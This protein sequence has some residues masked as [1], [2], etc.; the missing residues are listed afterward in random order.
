ME[1]V[2][3]AA[4]ILKVGGTYIELLQLATLLGTEFKG[5]GHRR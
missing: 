5:D 3:T 1:E 2:V 4:A